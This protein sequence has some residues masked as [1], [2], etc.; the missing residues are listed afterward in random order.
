MGGV[1]LISIGEAADRLGLRPSALRYYDERGLVA[2]PTRRAGRRMYGTDE[3][4]RLAFLTIARRLGIPLDTAAA[5]LDEPGPD[6]RAAVREQIVELD[7]LAEQI[8]GARLFLD[9]ALDCPTE[10]PT[11]DCP[12]MTTALDR[13]LAGITLEQLGREQ[14]GPINA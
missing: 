4:R 11:R 9:H 10:H 3:M 8:R 7:R 1:D 5:V 14:G 6:W 13:F 2:P 12:T